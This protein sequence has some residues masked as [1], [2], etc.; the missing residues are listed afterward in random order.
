M[1]ADELTLDAEVGRREAVGRPSGGTRGI[2]VLRR[3]GSVAAALMFL[4]VGST[5]VC[6]V[7]GIL[8]AEQVRGWLTVLPPFWTAAAIFSLLAADVFL[9]VPSSV[10]LAFGGWALGWPVGTLVGAGGV[11]AGNLVGYWVCRLAGTRAFDQLVG[12]A[13]AERFGKWLDR[14]GAF[15]VA[16]SRSVPAVAETLS[17]MAGFGRMRAGRFTAA[18]VLGTMPVAFAFAI[19]GAAAR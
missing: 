5:G 9:P 6:Y 10:L 19:L 3:I 2:V 11:I 7:L 13:E 15:A 17:C 12:A 4:F 14:W 18:L 16:L 8:S 1:K